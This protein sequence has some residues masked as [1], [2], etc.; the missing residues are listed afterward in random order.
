MTSTEGLV[1][2]FSQV[3]AGGTAQL[4]ATYHIFVHHTVTQLHGAQLTADHIHLAQFHP[5]CARQCRCVSLRLLTCI[6]SFS[7]P[8]KLTTS[9]C[10][11]LGL[12]KEKVPSAEVVVPWGGSLPEEVGTRNRVAQ[13]ILYRSLYLRLQGGE[14]EQKN[15]YQTIFISVF[16]T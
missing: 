15:G 3:T 5:F 12:D 2:N 1:T 9:I 16:Y 7:K 4:G 13:I 6:V 10:L 11:S 14:R 8:I